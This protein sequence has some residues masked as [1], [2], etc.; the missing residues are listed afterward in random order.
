MF[1]ND[2]KPSQVNVKGLRSRVVA[3]GNQLISRIKG[4]SSEK[5][6]EDGGVKQPEYKSKWD[7]FC[8]FTSLVGFRL[9]SSKNSVWLRLISFLVMIISCVLIF[10]QTQAA[11]TRFL[12]SGDLSIA[13]VHEVENQP[14]SQPQFL[15]CISHQA[16]YDL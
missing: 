12:S 2:R 13:N 15:F 1:P 7:Q 8:D 11:V 3:G 14:L 16:L 5:E 9:L 10:T 4:R 6:D